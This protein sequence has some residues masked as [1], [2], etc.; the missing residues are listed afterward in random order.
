MFDGHFGK[1]HRL[2][3]AAAFCLAVLLS[4]APAALAVPVLPQSEDPAVG[5]PGGGAAP[6][7]VIE[8]S[9]G[10]D[11]TDGVLVGAVGFALA[12]AAIALVAAVRSPSPEPTPRA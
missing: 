9:G 5:A 1:R 6:A 2:A 11:W 7:T 4:A 12:I 3:A 8:T 10:S